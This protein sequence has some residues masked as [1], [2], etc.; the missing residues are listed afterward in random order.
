MLQ[1][2]QISQSTCSFLTTDIDRT[3]QFQLSSK[4]HKNP[5]NPPGRH[6][7]SGS[8]GPT[9]R[10]SQFVDYFK[11]PLV[12]LNQSFIRD[13]THLINILNDLTLQPGM[14]LCTLT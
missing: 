12:P 7:V 3:Q 6:I 14:L 13:L 4:I 10:I 11:G 5:E 2:G 1:K 8:G 9:E